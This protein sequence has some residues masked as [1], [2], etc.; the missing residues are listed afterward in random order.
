MKKKVS[1]KTMT[2]KKAVSAKKT[3]TRK[4]TKKS[5]SPSKPDT[6]SMDITPEKR[7]K[8]IAVAAYHKAEKRGFAP[9][10]ELQDWS[11]A[12]KGIDKLMFG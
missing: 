6:S 8:I 10:Y 12:E 2:K 5:T 3:A 7:W 1:K 11:E 9:G 4:A